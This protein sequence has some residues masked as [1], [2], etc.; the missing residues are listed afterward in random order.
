MV[1]RQVLLK[2]LATSLNAA[3]PVAL[4]EAALEIYEMLFAQSVVGGEELPTACIGLFSFFG[5]ANVKNKTRMI[6]ILG[7]HLPAFGRDLQLLAIGLAITILPSLNEMHEALVREVGGLLDL[8]ARPEL[9]GVEV[10][11]EALWVAVLR[12]PGCR[13]AGLKFISSKLG[14]GA[15]QEEN[16]EEDTFWNEVSSMSRKQEEVCAAE[17]EE[18]EKSEADLLREYCPNMETL[19]VNSLTICIE[20][21]NVLAIKASLDFLYKYLPLR[22]DSISEAAK[23]RLARSVVWLLGK[24]D[25]SVTRKINLWLFGKPDDENQYQVDQTHLSFVTDVLIDFLQKEMSLEPLKIAINL[26]TEHEALPALI[27]GQLVPHLL[28][29]C[30][31]QE[32]HN[33]NAKEVTKHMHRLIDRVRPHLPLFSLALS[34]ALT[35]ALA[36]AHFADAEKSIA[37]SAYFVGRIAKPEDLQGAVRSFL[38]LLLEASVLTRWQDRPLMRLALGKT[39]ELLERHKDL[40]RESRTGEAELQLLL[41]HNG[42]FSDLL[43]RVAARGEQEVFE[44][45]VA[46]MNRLLAKVEEVFEIAG[47][48]WLPNTV[49]NIALSNPQHFLAAIE[50]VGEVVERESRLGREVQAQAR[51]AGRSNFVRRSLEKLWGILS[52]G[53]LQSR[54]I[55]LLLRLVRGFPVYF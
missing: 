7:K 36:R 30:M 18:K 39:I 47:E 11:A 37:L 21:S 27:L 22:S 17:G 2:R 51:A 20:D 40:L 25:T 55:P 43:G 31:K 38:K 33:E 52:L 10:L 24:R 45:E 13:V 16:D 41:E 6:E 4:H 14:R 9:I 26:L 44:E 12:S 34:E 49:R 19:V 35:A 5:Q 32:G 42:L 15:Q 23:K 46:L 29:F 54:V 28:E 53:H 48:E 8:L 1:D 50:A 3:L